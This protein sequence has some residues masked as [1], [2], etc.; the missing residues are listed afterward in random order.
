M[1]MSVPE[2]VLRDL[3]PH[4]VRPIFTTVL[5]REKVRGELA[6]GA[7]LAAKQ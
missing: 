3:E 2:H 5:A 1:H 6:V 7:G 4:G